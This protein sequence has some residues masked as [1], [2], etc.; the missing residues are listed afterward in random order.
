M[1]PFWRFTDVVLRGFQYLVEGVRSFWNRRLLGQHNAMEA[2]VGT[3]AHL[4]VD[5][6]S[7]ANDQESGGAEGDIVQQLSAGGISIPSVALERE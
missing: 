1:L 5:E 6:S 3:L 4:E 2:L 7:S